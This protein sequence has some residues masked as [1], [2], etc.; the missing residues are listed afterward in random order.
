MYRPIVGL[1]QKE[2]DKFA[3][4]TK[5]AAIRRE[6]LDELESAI[7]AKVDE[8]LNE[9]QADLQKGYKV[10]DLENDVLEIKI[11]LVNDASGKAQKAAEDRID[12]H[13]RMTELTNREWG[14]FINSFGF[15]GFLQRL[16]S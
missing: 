2:R 3:E 11:A 16:F 7:K 10:L 14:L 1:G 12:K 15:A 13:Q 8:E 9:L 5:E 6:Q 4:A